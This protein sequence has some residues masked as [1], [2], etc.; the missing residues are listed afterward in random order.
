MKTIR[1]IRTITKKPWVT[2]PT[3]ATTPAMIQAFW[4]QLFREQT[5]YV[6]LEWLRGFGNVAYADP[7]I[8]PFIVRLYHDVPDD[9][10]VAYLSIVGSHVQWRLGTKDIGHAHCPLV[11]DPA[12]LACLDGLFWWH[13]VTLEERKKK[14]GRPTLAHR[15][16]IDWIRQQS[17]YVNRTN[18]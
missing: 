15:R 4:H 11:T 6:I 16:A 17:H 1:T 3:P 7:D 2:P 9:P 18:A 12:Q 14:I 5:N 10:R 8:S 13:T